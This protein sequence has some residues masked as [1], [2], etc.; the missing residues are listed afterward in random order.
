[1]SVA[2][3][4]PSASVVPHI[5]AAT[6]ENVLSAASVA[7]TAAHVAKV[8]ELLRRVPADGLGGA[9][10]ELVVAAQHWLVAVEMV[11]LPRF[12]DARALAAAA[13]VRP[14][15][16]QHW[17]RVHAAVCGDREED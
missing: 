13:A 10:R 2:L 1:M 15:P 11:A 17:Q 8:R 7:P 4:N 6:L 16:V 3:K 14:Q 5:W 9:W 12:A